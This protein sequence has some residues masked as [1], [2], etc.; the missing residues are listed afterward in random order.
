MEERT[1]ELT[2][3]NKNLRSEINE[4]KQAE[5]ELRESEKRYRDFFNSSSDLIMVHDLEAHLLNVNPAVSKLSGYTFE[6]MVGRPISEFINPKF[7]HLF[8]DQYLK[9]IREQGRSEGVVIFQT[10]DGTDHYVEYSN[11]LVQQIGQEPYVSGSGRDVTE[12]MR[13]VRELRESE[14]RYRDLFENANDM[15][16]AVKPDNSFIYVNRAWRETLG[17]SEE[18]I[19]GLSVFDIIDPA[20]KEH[21]MD[22]FQR[23]MRGE[24]V[25]KIVASFICKD[26]KRIIVEGNI[27]CRFKDG[28]P[29]STRAIFRDITERKQAEEALRE[30]EERYRSVLEANPDPVVVYDMEGKVIYF[31]PA[32]TVVFGWSLSDRVGKKMDA[33]VPEEN[34]PETIEMIEKVKRGE[35]FYGVETR[36]YAKSGDIIDISIS[37]AIW[38]DSRGVT[39]GSV[40][41]L[42]DIS[43]QKRLEAELLHAQRIESIG[44]I[45]SG[46]AHNFRNI[47]TAISANNQ[48]LEMKCREDEL[49]LEIAE[50]ING[51]VSRGAGL[52]DGLMQFSRK[53]ETAAFKFLNF[54]NVIQEIH[55]LIS[56]SFD[57]SIDIKVNVPESIPVMGDHLALSQV[58]MNLCT[59]ARDAMPRG[60]ELNIEAEKEGDNAVITISDMGHGMD[61]ETTDRCFDPFFTTKGIGKG[62]GLGLSTSYGIIKDHGGDIRVHSEVGKGTTFRVRIPM[63]LLGEAESKEVPSEAILGKGEKILVIDDETDV[64]E[65]MQA[66][67]KSIGYRVALASSGK[68]GIAKYL[69]WKPHVVL[70]DRNMPE[71]DGITCTE[72]ILEQD[73]AAKILLISGYD[74][75]GPDGIDFPTKEVIKGYLTKPLEMEKLSRFL[76]RLLNEQ[77]SS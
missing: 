38:R 16:Q 63:V 35:N 29:I 47:L 36:R 11:V 10:K 52:V 44:T 42:R 76:N 68:E 2:T 55:D 32:F 26:G 14:E 34:W 71:M 13:A 75:D 57:K 5:E 3:A 41:T 66:V 12:R 37:A 59:N 7:R 49:L 45:A 21:C 43:H 27:N 77:G 50:R 23:V 46:V 40:I 64:L 39:M 67:L 74:E 51:A 69:S 58:L 31:N 61:K 24:D 1:V 17:Y 53:G 73:P 48:L 25:E 19:S 9:Q 15:I 4:R 60:G 22:I 6:E 72:R 8:G 18:E 62:T 56:K 28:K 70:I 33:F 65:P 54:A 20:S 30:S